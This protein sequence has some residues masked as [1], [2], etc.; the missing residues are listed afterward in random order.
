MTESVLV[1]AIFMV[2]AFAAFVFLCYRGVGTAM[3]AIISTI[4]AAFGSTNDF[5]TSIFVV[6]PTGV[7]TQV[8]NLF[9]VF[10]MAGLLGIMMEKTGCSQAIG[11]KMVQVLG[12]E[13]SWL[14][15]TATTI[16]LVLAG[17]GSWVWIA[18]L[19]AG[20]LMKAANLPRRIG[21]VA[22][23][24]VAPM[25]NWAFP[26]NNMPGSIPH[27]YLG[28]NAFSAPLLSIVVG[29]VGLVLFLLYLTW[30]V[31]AVRAKGLGYDGPDVESSFDT[32]NMPRFL[33]SI[34]PVIAVVA[35]TIVFAV[36]DLNTLIGLNS[37]GQLVLAELIGCILIF[38]LHREKCIEFG[39][40]K[41]L[42]G[43]TNLWPMMLTACC[44]FGFG[45]VM[46]SSACISAMQE[47]IL[48]LQI[49]PYVSIMLSMMVITAMTSDG[50]AGMLVWLP[51]FGQSYLD[52]GVDPGAMRRMIMTSSCTF[53]SLP[54]SQTIASNLAAFG[55]THK[56]GYKDLFVTTV[57]IPVIFSVVCC[58]L[59]IVFY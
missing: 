7:S 26:I 32:E 4:I 25:I 42:R 23:C 57:I 31:K 9:L 14:A 37:N 55:L 36:M 38:L 59:C 8:L 3:A 52:M 19:I 2:L 22:A 33:P 51:M 56:E 30:Q 34:I 17:I 12:T 44:V 49:N 11:A 48:G 58:V 35:L 6:F 43:F 10:S 39:I 45:K 41:L 40:P 13:R 47:A 16:I 15:I 27:A 21:M 1:S 24:G 53:D 28:T 46:T 18:I 5:I 54:Q 50:I 29:L 20:P